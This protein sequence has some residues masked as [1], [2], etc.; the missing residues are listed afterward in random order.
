[1]LQL[2][3]EACGEGK[4]TLTRD[5]F[6][7][8]AESFGIK[9]LDALAFF[10][11]ID[12]DGDGSLDYREFFL[13][14]AAA[15]P[16]APLDT[17]VGESDTL[18]WRQQR[19]SYIFRL[20]DADH[21]GQLDYG[22]LCTIVHHLLKAQCGSQEKV[23]DELVKQEADKLVKNRTTTVSEAEFVHVVGNPNQTF[24][25]TDLILKSKLDPKLWA[26]VTATLQPQKGVA[27]SLVN[28]GR[29]PDAV[30]QRGAVHKRLGNLVAAERDYRTALRFDPADPAAASGLESTL[31]L[32]QKL[33]AEVDGVRKAMV[34]KCTELG[35]NVGGAF[36][37][38][39]SDG[40]GNINHQEFRDGLLSLQIAVTDEQIQQM[41]RTIDQDGDGQIDANEF[42]VWA[43]TD[44]PTVG[45]KAAMP[46]EQVALQMAEGERLYNAGQ[47]EESRIDASRHYKDAIVCFTTA[48]DGDLGGASVFDAY[49][50]LGL[51][52][53]NLGTGHE[54]AAFDA[55]GKR[56]QLVAT[57]FATA[58]DFP[59]MQQTHVE[60][61]PHTVGRIQLII[62]LITPLVI[63][64]QGGG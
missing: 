25:N 9:K 38:F 53:E 47:D 33:A 30:S 43:L 10:D 7:A 12:S 50:L 15:D 52:H 13:G 51:C 48:L 35:F 59:S 36:S 49:S 21:D 46:A 55:F 2:F 23:S 1:M 64:H 26:A 37:E 44:Q 57:I 22:E 4:N 34:S 5:R 14:L 31:I 8:A 42:E 18:A 27:D 45:A 40:D 6:V 58:A 41:I 20:Y 62:Q 28:P 29:N 11:A 61:S 60:F 54:E 39:D 19:A 17:S 32:V 56:P 16:Q 63:S 24:L 3:R